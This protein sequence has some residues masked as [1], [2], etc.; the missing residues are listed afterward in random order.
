MTTGEVIS[1]FGTGSK[2][3]ELLGISKAA[4]SNWGKYP[5]RGRQCEIEILTKGKLKAEPKPTNRVA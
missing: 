5:P 2:V 4:V 1:E 3:A